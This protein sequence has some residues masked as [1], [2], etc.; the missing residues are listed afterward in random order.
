MDA[1]IETLFKQGH[2]WGA[3]ILG[4]L[5]FVVLPRVDKLI[6]RHTKFLDSTDAQVTKQTQTG[7]ATAACLERLEKNQTE[8]MQICRASGKPVTA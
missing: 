3:A 1:L 7:I 4:L 2:I 5:Y 8:H 6:D